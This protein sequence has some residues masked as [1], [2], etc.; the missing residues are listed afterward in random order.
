[1]SQSGEFCL[2]CGSDRI[3][4]NV[5]L[6]DHFGDWGMSSRQTK[7][8]VHGEPRAFIMRDTETAELSLR[9]CGSCGHA[10]LTVNNPERL[11]EKH[12]KSISSS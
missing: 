9:I 6:T 4:P 10:E 8:E 5:P 11:W 2:R 7:V 12:L 1:M 3:I